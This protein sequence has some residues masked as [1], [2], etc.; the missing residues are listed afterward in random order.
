MKLIKLIEAD[1]KDWDKRNTGVT[2]LHILEP[3]QFDLER[4][5]AMTSVN[6]LDTIVVYTKLKIA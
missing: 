6:D 5:L 3:S 4:A 2:E 1:V